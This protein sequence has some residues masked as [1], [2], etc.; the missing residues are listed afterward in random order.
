MSSTTTAETVAANLGT[1]RDQ[2]AKLTRDAGRDKAP[3]LLA[4]SKT[5]PVELLMACYAAGQ[6]RF[7]ENYVQEL[8]DKQKE[9]PADIEWHF[10]GHLQSNKA[11][12]VARLPNI[13]MVESV[14]S[15]KLADQ[16]NKGRVNAQLDPNPGLLNVMVQVNTSG[17]ESKAGVEPDDVVALCKHVVDNCDALKLAGLMTIGAPDTSETPPCLVLL[18]KLR[19][20]VASELTLAVDDLE[21]SMGMSG[22]M[23]AAIRLG[24]T[25]VRV[26][27]AIFGAREYP[28]K[29]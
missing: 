29:A 26:G 28:A 11:K 16:L 9:M 23:A 21:L 15:A 27:S 7:G 20:Q 6:R 22:D 17:E 13:A 4:V 10:I 19:E 8:V 18:A 14:D 3:R 5:K 1:I 25:N 24:S 2:V 12:M